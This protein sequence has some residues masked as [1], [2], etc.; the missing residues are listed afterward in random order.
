MDGNPVNILLVDDSEAWCAALKLALQR[1][2]FTVRW[3]GCVED[4]KAVL[5]EWEV[6]CI[7]SDFTMPG[8]SGGDLFDFVKEK[9]PH[10]IDKGRYIFVTSSAETVKRHLDGLDLHIREKPIP[11]SEVLD[12]VTNKKWEARLLGK[13]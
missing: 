8:L 2:G 10:L 7:I 5:S 12:L 4:G 13:A 9:Y 1:L 11:L 3:V 6:D